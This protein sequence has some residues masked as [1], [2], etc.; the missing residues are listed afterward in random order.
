MNESPLSPAGSE[1]RVRKP[2]TARRSLEEPRQETEPKRPERKT[3]RTERGPKA[4]GKRDV[5]SLRGR[6][7]AHD[8]F[9]LIRWLALS[10]TDP[11][12]ALAE[13]VQNS[14]DA[15]AT[16]VRITRAREKGVVC[17][18]VV[19][20]GE[21]PI[22]EKDRPEALS[23]IATNIGHS[24]KRS[25]S[26][27]E[28]LQ[29]MTQGQYGIGLLGFWAIGEKLEMRSVLPGQKAH[30]L[31]L[32]RDTPDFVIETLR[33]R[34]DLSERR[35][36]VVVVG[37]HPEVQSALTGRRIAE[38]LA[39][40][41]RGQL[42][43]RSVTLEVEDKIARGRSQKWFEVAPR[44]FLGRPIDGAKAI[45]VPGHSPMQVELY[46]LG[47]DVSEAAAVPI[48]LY[49]AGTMVATS[50]HELSELGLDRHP[51][52]DRRFTGFVDF[53][54]FAIAPGS[55]RG[56]TVDAA[57]EAFA[58][59][60]V[61][62]EP[63]LRAVIEER[64]RARTVEQDR[65]LIK[66][67]QRAFRNF[68][69][70]R[71]RFELLP[72]SD[73]ATGGHGPGAGSG[74]GG[75]AGL[76]DADA[77]TDG[78]RTGTDRLSEADID[79]AVGEAAPNPP[80][81]PGDDSPEDDR[82]AEGNPESATD[83]DDSDEADVDEPEAEGPDPIRPDL[84]LFPPGPVSAVRFVPKSIRIPTESEKSIRAEAIDATGRVVRELMEFDWRLEGD[85]GILVES[86]GPELST[87]SETGTCE[88]QIRAGDAPGTGRLFVEVRTDQES[89]QGE[90]AVRV[91]EGG[92]ARS[93]G[94]PEPEFL[95]A[96]GSA[97]RSRMESGRWQVNSGHPDFRRTAER[98][99]LRLRY[100]AM[101]FA[102]E[103]VL[104][105]HRDPRMEQGLE[106]MIE[107]SAFADRNLSTK[108]DR[109]EPR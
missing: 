30:R 81:G 71:P 1:G 47:D 39:S 88:V 42:L 69:R 45:V 9:E 85:C 27:Q 35:T 16:R 91:V 62:V 4:R 5:D 101:L 109:G 73:P 46:Y 54:G 52:T 74:T 50:F 48:A 26:P 61:A 93:E 98:P 102:K 72:V 103:V 24:R 25:L 7:R 100:L 51:W 31:V 87:I 21:G 10:Q 18:R 86:D 90:V 37:V 76:E 41:L 78:S 70:N 77:A 28:R 8:P 44:R 20:N 14:L 79:P 57:A 59:A 65:N 89:A 92:A 96:P 68:Y 38:Y 23:F 19:D 3:P 36:E 60:I 6:V 108:R 56:V 40:E 55:R 83:R 43:A 94:I 33:N 53:A 75:D 84:F 107:V 17:I 2:E 12:K 13:L 63:V 66:N 105:S 32:H 106:Q 49:A 95:D 15:S 104:R 64:E 34:L 82:S 99:A 97:W 67:L 58:H 11:R 29:L 80:R 22:P